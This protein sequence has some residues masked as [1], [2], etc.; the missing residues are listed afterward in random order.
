MKVQRTKLV[1]YVYLLGILLTHPPPSGDFFLIGEENMMKSKIKGK[2]GEK[3]GEQ[4]E[5]K[6]GK[7][8]KKVKKER[9]YHLGEEL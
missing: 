7:K 9:K 6:K 3:R 8:V 4:R 2:K 1:H 5:R